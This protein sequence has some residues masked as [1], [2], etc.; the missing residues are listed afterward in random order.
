MLHV[1]HTK[2]TRIVV[3]VLKYEMLQKKTRRSHPAVFMAFLY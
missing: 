2:R 1:A 3:C